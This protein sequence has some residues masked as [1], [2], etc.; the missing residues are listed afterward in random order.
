MQGFDFKIKRLRRE[1][2]QWEL[3][4]LSDIPPYRISSFERGRTD[5]TLEELKR[6]R[7]ALLPECTQKVG[8]GGGI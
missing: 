2:S 7:A 4:R 6:L 8:G 1:L 3:A 5:L